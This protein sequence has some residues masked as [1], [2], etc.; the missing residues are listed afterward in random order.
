MQKRNE[1]QNLLETIDKFSYSE[2]MEK[3]KKDPLLS[4]DFKYACCGR[5]MGEEGEEKCSH[6]TTI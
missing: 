6:F 3:I 4:N 1:I 5:R 2:V